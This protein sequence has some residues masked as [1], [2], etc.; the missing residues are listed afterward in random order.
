M[1]LDEGDYLEHYGILRK[2]GRY[3]WGSGK[4]QSA[5]NRSFL[6][7]IDDLKR[8]GMTESEIARGFGMTTTQLRSIKT[9][10]INE[11]TQAKVNQAQRLKEKGYSN[12]AIGERM[13][14]NESSVRSL[15]APG[16]KD[17]LDIL[18]ATS[19]MLRDQVEK[20]K[21]LD[22][23]RGVELSLPISDGGN[24]GITSTKFKTAIALLKEE[25]YKEHYV[26]IPQLGTNQL[27]T[28]K[29]LTKPD[30]PYSEVFKNRDKIQ[31][32]SEFSDDGGR[33]YLGL[34]PPTNVSSKR[35]MVA[36][37]KDGGTSKDGV[38]EIRPNAKDLSLGAAKYAQVRI[39]V[40]GTHYLKGMAIHNPDLPPGVDIRFNTNKKDTGNKLDAMKP[41]EKKPDGSIDMDNPFGATIKPGGQRG[42]LNI[43]YEEGDWD[44]WS[45]NLP[46]QV[47][48]KQSPK[49]A[50]D[51]LNL[52]YERRR[53]SLDEIM[54]LTNPVVKKKLLE[55][56]ADDADS[57]AV[58]LKAAYMPRQATRVLLPINSM[59]ADEI[60]AP[61]FKDGERVA[62]IRFPHGGTFEIPQLT[63]NNRNRE[64]RALLG[65]HAR[66]AVGINSKVAERLSGADFDGDNVLVIPNNRGLIKSTPALEGLKDFDPKSAY[67]AY[68]GM[69][70]IN[71]IDGKDSARKQKEMGKITNLIADMTIRGAGPADLARAVRHSMVV[72]DA[73]KHNLDFKGS[74]RDNGITQLKIKYQGSAKSGA[75]TLITR[76][77]ADFRVNERKV[78][79]VDRT[80]GKKVFEETG[81]TYVNNKGKVVP[82]TTLTTRLAET[83]D[84]HSLSS[85]TPIESV[86][87]D[88]SNRL[89]ALANIARKEA[90]SVQ[91]IPYSPSAKAVYSNEVA[92][93]NSK[94][95]I[96]KRNA[97]LERQAQILANAVVAQK[98]RDNPHMDD[99]DLKKIKN[100]ALAEA[101]IRTGAKKQ[102]IDIT[103]EEWNAIQ[104]GAITKSKLESI[105]NNTDL[106]LVKALA[107]PKQKVV[108][109]S[110]KKQHARALLAAGYT[111]AEV[112]DRLGVSVSTL[113]TGINE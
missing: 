41:M 55:S 99:S 79:P 88:H 46:S 97:P 105:L 25:G 64:A 94:L 101:R 30:V 49:L 102:R 56:F 81:A 20:K 74:A 19:D 35:I 54:D 29:V 69:V 82:K 73:E 107:T 36:Y 47:L 43:I 113:M 4:T 27:T 42:A 23:G 17:K 62:L 9:I 33:S 111:Q 2:S 1:I 24:I 91:A 5:Q 3:P 84:A 39:A 86:Y 14:I 95:N 57:A 96:A 85:G 60:Y 18:K 112:A 80:T 93:L 68:P 16:K 53:T 40:D 72:I 26:K 45:K 92:S 98:K 67:P 44:M 52:S 34:R 8:Q 90:V 21:Y 75:S 61:S 59:R 15:L 50:K 110:L 103:K 83:D 76:G 104:A 7:T 87:A 38:I 71:G 51:Q 11:Q 89:K 32:I 78:R 48:S 37:D 10:A 58:H 65:S 63:V 106:D 66:D 28:I 100:Q 12:V 109:N 31:Q 13:G 77:P 22:I 6:D 108:M 70:P